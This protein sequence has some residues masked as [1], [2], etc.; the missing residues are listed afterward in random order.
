M[1]EKLFTKKLSIKRSACLLLCVIIS[2]MSTFGIN[3]AM[4]SQN[5][6]DLDENKQMTI[7]HY[8]MLGLNPYTEGVY[9]EEDMVY[10][11]DFPDVKSR[12]KANLEVAKS[13]LKSMG[14]KGY[15]ELLIKKNISTSIPGGITLL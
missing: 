4:C 12:Q 2:F 14:A 10:S 6:T 7:T 9:C 11:R 8:L 13:R 5:K 3:K 1:A 15:I